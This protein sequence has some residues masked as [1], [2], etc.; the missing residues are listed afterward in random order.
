M[1]RMAWE[2]K[3]AAHKRW[4][5]AAWKRVM[6]AFMRGD[7][8]PRA[9]AGFNPDQPRDEL[10][11]WAD[12]AAA[13]AD[14]GAT[15]DERS[16]E[17]DA[18]SSPQPVQDRTDRL[19][20]RHIIDNHVAKTDEELKERIR[21]EQFRGL[22]QT[23]GRDR[24]GSFDSVESARDFISQTI[25]NNPGDV[26]RVASG[27]LDESFLVWRFGYQTGR[28]AIMDPPGSE[29]RIRPTYEVGVY[30]VHDPRSDFGYRVVSAYPKNYNPRTGR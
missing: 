11:R 7:F 5:D 2:A 3:C 26:A 13:V 16:S 29:I 15:N 8:A 23:I 6:A 20:N 27:V 25:A 21:R 18:D 9:K 12:G 24:N 1:R 19:L 17:G 22:F 4:A 14:S 28:E 10:G 30:V